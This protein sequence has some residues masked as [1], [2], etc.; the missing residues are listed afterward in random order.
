[1]TRAVGYARVSKADKRKG[2][3]QE[4]HSIEAQHQAIHRAA[5]YNGWKLLETYVD[6]GK[7]G[8]NT[9]RDG[10]QSALRVLSSGD[11]D[12]LVI[13]KYDRLSRNTVDFGT[14]INRSVKSTPA[15]PSVGTWPG[16]WRP[17]PS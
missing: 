17:T 13:A 5:E 16:S 11:A 2:K 3:Q 4:A 9:R 8:T 7:S 12:I 6:N 10:L 14:L 1:M 15:P